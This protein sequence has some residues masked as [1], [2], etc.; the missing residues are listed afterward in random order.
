MLI[1]SMKMLGES[2]FRRLFQNIK[3]KPRFQETV[4][5]GKHLD[6]GGN[7]CHSRNADIFR[8]YHS[9]EENEKCVKSVQRKNQAISPNEIMDNSHHIT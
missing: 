8:N 1:K 4:T 7:N 9:V 6:V 5:V 2:F 3:K